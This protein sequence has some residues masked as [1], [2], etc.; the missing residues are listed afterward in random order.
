MICWRLKEVMARYDIEG[1][2]LARKMEVHPNTVSSW[3]RSKTLPMTG[4]RLNELIHAL[5]ALGN[6]QEIVL[7]S[8]VE[9][10]PDGDL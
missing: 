6:T 9:F 10:V 4:D 5:R 2:A 8:L 3:R 7:D 1:V